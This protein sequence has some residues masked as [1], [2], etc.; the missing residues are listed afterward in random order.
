MKDGRGKRTGRFRLLKLAGEQ[1]GGTAHFGKEMALHVTE[2]DAAAQHHQPLLAVFLP[3]PTVAVRP[4]GRV[5]D[6]IEHLGTERDVGTQHALLQFL[7][8]IAV[9]LPYVDLARKP[10][11]VAPDVIEKLARTGFIQMLVQ[12]KRPFQRSIR[13]DAEI[14]PA[15]TSVGGNFSQAVEETLH[16]DTVPMEGRIQFRLPHAVIDPCG[17]GL[18][19]C[20]RMATIQQQ[21]NQNN[22]FH[23]YHFRNEPLIMR[24]TR[25]CRRLI[26][27][28][29][30]IPEMPL[31]SRYGRR[32]K[33][34][35]N[36]TM[37]IFYWKN[38]A[39]LREYDYL[40]RIKRTIKQSSVLFPFPSFFLGI[41]CLLYFGTPFPE[42]GERVPRHAKMPA[43]FRHRPVF[44]EHT[45][46]GSEVL[47]QNPALGITSRF[48]PQRHASR[49]PQGKRLAGT[50]GDKVALYLRHQPEGEA[51][52]LAVDGIV[53]R[54]SLL[55]GVKPDAFLQAKPH[56]AHDVGQRAAQARHLG[57]DERV[58][59][60][61]LP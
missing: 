20:H 45:D 25:R 34:G 31:S 39:F 32:R 41:Q 49:L 58:A 36:D 38:L 10:D 5:T 54:I 43:Y 6:D 18:Y 14:E 23:V 48:P 44:V 28:L 55:R 50:Q 42:L 27:R 35:I 61:H 29:T 4:F 7:P 1:D 59:P 40:C 33:G 57:H 24:K 12:G 21:D 26:V 22:L 16:G 46:N 53:E 37:T 9:V 3:F 60:L 30:V 17:I 56:D 15:V 11:A 47:R 51:K 52:H 13:R 19:L 2:G 8:V